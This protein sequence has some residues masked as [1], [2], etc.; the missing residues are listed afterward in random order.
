[1]NDYVPLDK[2]R[3]QEQRQRQDR[4][5]MPRGRQVQ[6]IE[7]RAKMAGLT[8]ACSLAGKP[9]PERQWMVKDLIPARGVTLFSAHGGTG[10]SLMGLQL[11]ACA[12]L[13]KPWLGFE[14]RNVKTAVVSCED[15]RDEMHRRLA[16]ICAAEGWDIGDLQD[17]ALFDRVGQENAIMKLE[18]QTWSWEETPFWLLLY[19]FCVDKG[20]QLV[21]LDSLYD[22]FTGNQLDS[23]NV[24]AFMEKLNF[25]ARE[26]DGGVVTLWHPSQSGRASGDGTSG[27]N[28]FHNKARGRLYMTK[29]EEDPRVRIIKNAKQNYAEDGDEV[30]RVRWEGGRFVR[31]LDQQDNDQP[32]GVFAGMAKRNAERAFLA[33]LDAINA[34]QRPVSDKKRAGNYAPKLLVTMPQAKGTKVEALEKAMLDLMA[35]GT[36]GIGF[37]GIGADRHK[38]FGL[39]RKDQKSPSEEEA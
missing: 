20:I 16:A 11:A 5:A 13:G 1:M 15:D 36:I 35:A 28:A 37:V 21:V 32:T 10:K 34:Q 27:S 33:A 7:S 8:W 26:I 25:L 4:N 30:A 3:R 9:V 23:G 38:L 29:D 24:H 17:L 18:R 6:D 14:T 31:I 12:E 2:A 39:V 19:N 22:F